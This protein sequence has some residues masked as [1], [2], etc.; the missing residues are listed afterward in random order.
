MGAFVDHKFDKG[1][2]LDEERIRRINE[3]LL[4]RS[5]QLPEE[6][7]ILYKIYRADSFTYPTDDIEQIFDEDNADW[8]RMVRLTV[9][10]DLREELSLK[11]DFG[12]VE[13]SLHIESEDRD[14]VFLLFSEL[15]QYLL[16]EVNT[17]RPIARILATAVGVLLMVGALLFLVYMFWR[18]DQLVGVPTTVPCE[19]VLQSDD[20]ADK[21]NFLIE[22]G[23]PTADTSMLS[24]MWPMF[25]AM[26]FMAVSWPLR[27]KLTKP[28]AYLYPGSI[29]LLGKELGRHAKRERLRNNLLW[30]VIIS[31]MVSVIAGIADLFFGK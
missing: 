29:F 17:I 2:L 10:M 7:K 24:V 11:L 6:G 20:L 30:G 23:T 8:N 21:L 28:I 26:L 4:N 25:A 18:V 3:I 22:R 5:Q 16:N 9:E 12:E 14:A 19:V 31:F 13:T 1:F 15:R 27:D